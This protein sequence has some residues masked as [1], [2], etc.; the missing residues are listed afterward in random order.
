MQRQRI[1]KEQ[2]PNLDVSKYLPDEKI[3]GLVREAVEKIKAQNNKENFSE[4]GQIKLKSIFE[5]LDAKVEYDDI[6]I[7][8]LVC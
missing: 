8:L 3:I 4:N 7:A 1:L 2:E 5:A 6:H